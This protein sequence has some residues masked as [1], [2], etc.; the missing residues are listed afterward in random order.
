MPKAETQHAEI[1]AQQE[2]ISGGTF[3]SDSQ[4]YNS[5]E[6][7]IAACVNGT[8]VPLQ[9]CRVTLE[10]S[11]DD[12]TWVRGANKAF[13]PAE[14]VVHLA[15]FV[16]SE[17][18]ATG[19][20]RHWRLTFKG[21]EGGPV[22]I[23]ASTGEA[24]VYVPPEPPPEGGATKKKDHEAPGHKAHEEHKPQHGHAEKK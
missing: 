12:V 2:L 8:P 21:N 14:G 15:A 11:T 16:L 13:G 24:P 17:F 9:Q 1:V 19:P 7:V 22:T 18:A 3:T 5:E 4:E 23:A 20:W 10:L 6:V